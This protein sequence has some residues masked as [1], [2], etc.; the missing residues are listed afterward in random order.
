M[1]QIGRYQLP[2]ASIV[3]L[4]KRTG[5]KSWLRD[6]YDVLLTNG[7]TIHFTAEEKAAY[8]AAMQLHQETLQV[9]GLCVARGLRPQPTR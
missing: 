6:G 1:I 2:L 7:K 9:Y 5:I 4:T 8:D 3:T